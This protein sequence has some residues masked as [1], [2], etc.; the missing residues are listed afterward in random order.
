M[1][2]YELVYIMRQDAS[3][4]DVDKF[5]EDFTKIATEY[6]VIIVK[7]E[8][9]GLRTL[10]YEIDNNKK[11]HYTLLAVE[12]KN[13]K[14]TSKFLQEIHRRAKLNENIIRSLV[15]KVDAIEKEPSAI[16][17]NKNNDNEEVVNVTVNKNA[18]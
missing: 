11:G 14:N 12:G 5:V 1:A 6:E 18:N 13:A 10:A 17:R 16:L 4:T 8:Y 9:W 2:F 15:L 3:T 7:N